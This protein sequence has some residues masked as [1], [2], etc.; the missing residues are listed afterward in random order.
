MLIKL[1]FNAGSLGVVR[2]GPIAVHPGSTLSP[3]VW[4][5]VRNDQT[6]RA[7]FEHYASDRLQEAFDIASKAGVGQAGEYAEPLQVIDAEQETGRRSE[8]TRI[9]E[10][11][12][13]ESIPSERTLS[14]F[15]TGEAAERAI[16]SMF[17]AIG[18][19]VGSPV[20]VT[21]LAR[22]VVLP[23]HLDR[24]GYVVLKNPYA[25]YCVPEEAARSMDSLEAHLEG[26]AACHAA[27]VISYESAAPWMVAATEALSRLWVDDAT[28]HQ[29]C[30]GQL[31][32]VE[33]GELNLRLIGMHLGDE[34]GDT[35][36]AALAQAIL[37]GRYL[38][39][40]AKP[41]ALREC[42]AYHAPT[43]LYH[44]LQLLLSNDPTRDICKKVYGF[45]PE[46]LFEQALAACCRGR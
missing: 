39:R 21:I 41:A 5:M 31:K 19:K 26:L 27:G 6:W 33:P 29:F 2:P 25:K 38:L 10:W 40:L 24:S 30:S 23:A 3:A 1:A 14:V 46:Y 7:S 45:A 11:L 4:G 18:L 17:A 9:N 32:W 36:S 20:L 13:V 12:E 28:R 16:A 42:L 43:N 44:S 37:V 8:I 15:D 22:E 35:T 34:P